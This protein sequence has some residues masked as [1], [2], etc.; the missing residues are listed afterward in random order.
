MQ[1]YRTATRLAMAGLAAGK[2]AVLRQVDHVFST[3]FRP[4]CSDHF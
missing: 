2:P 4:H 1:G 3:R